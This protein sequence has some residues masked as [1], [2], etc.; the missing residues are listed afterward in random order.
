MGYHFYIEMTSNAAHTIISFYVLVNGVK[1][2]ES[3]VG[4]IFRFDLL[5]IEFLRANPSGRWQ[6]LNAEKIFEFIF[7]FFRAIVIVIAVAVQI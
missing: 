3:E 7:F 4:F 1:F 2:T 6:Q 5:E